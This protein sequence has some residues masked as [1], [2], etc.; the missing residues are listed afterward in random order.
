VGVLICIK[1]PSFRV[2]QQS[3]ATDQPRQWGDGP[4]N[5]ETLLSGRIEKYQNNQ[6][7]PVQ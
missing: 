2:I 6:T 5:G 3:S 4:P 1:E 7:D